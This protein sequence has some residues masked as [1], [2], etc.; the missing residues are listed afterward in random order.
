MIYKYFW[1]NPVRPR[2][3]AVM[4]QGE[5]IFIGSMFSVICLGLC[6]FGGYDIGET[7]EETIQTG[8]VGAILGFLALFSSIIYEQG[9]MRVY[10]QGQ[11]LQ[12]LGEAALEYIVGVGLLIAQLMTEGQMQRDIATINFFLFLNYG[13]IGWGLYFVYFIKTKKRKPGDKIFFVWI[14]QQMWNSFCI[15]ATLF[16][17]L[18]VTEMRFRSSYK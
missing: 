7:D 13:F 15:G 1:R 4:W 12:T 17:G 5:A 2:T 9:W 18:F 8:T 6:D 16:L 3:D 10:G 11:R 14:Q